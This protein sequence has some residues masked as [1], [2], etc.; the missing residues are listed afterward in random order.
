MRK[1]KKNQQNQNPF[2]VTSNQSYGLSLNDQKSQKSQFTT[3]RRETQK[4]TDS[5]EYDLSFLYSRESDRTG[6]GISYS[7]SALAKVLLGQKTSLYET[8]KRR[9]INSTSNNAHT[10]VPHEM[11]T[12]P[13]KE[14]IQRELKSYVHNPVQQNALYMTSSNAYGSKAPTEETYSAVCAAR[15]QSFSS[16]F[17]RQMT[18]DQGLNT[19]MTRSKVHCVLDPQFI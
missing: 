5:R 12:K 17:N 8:K 14:Q 1:L 15:S 16:S 6:Q 19:S 13:T 3:R 9:T 4:S 11:S 18:R 10:A 7:D 2:L